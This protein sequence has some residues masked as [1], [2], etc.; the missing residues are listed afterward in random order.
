MAARHVAES[1]PGCSALGVRV[2]GLRVAEPHHDATPHW[3]AL[4]WCEN[5]DAAQTLEAVIRHH[6]LSDDGDEQG[7]L[8]QRQAHDEG[9]RGGLRGQVHRQERYHIALAE[10]QDLVEGQQLALHFP[11][12]SMVAS[13]Q[14]GS[15]HHRVDAWAAT[16]GIRQFQTIGMPSV[17][18]VA[19][20][21]PGDG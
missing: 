9:R 12:R 16:W 7:E 2:Y 21:A 11:C 15:G 20:A 17:D 18:G 3:H 1:T 13:K 5:E 6:W 14:T 8:H 4:L 10:H 19:R